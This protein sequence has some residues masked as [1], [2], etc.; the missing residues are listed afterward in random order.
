M[1]PPNAN[2]I[3]SNCVATHPHKPETGAALSFADWNA[4][5]ILRVLATIVQRLGFRERSEE[6]SELRCPYV[7]DTSRMYCDRT[8]P[9]AYPA[10]ILQATTCW[11]KPELVELAVHQIFQRI[12]AKTTSVG[13]K[14]NKKTL[15][16]R[17]EVPSNPRA[18]L[19]IFLNL[20]SRQ[21]QQGQSV[22]EDYARGVQIFKS[23]FLQYGHPELADSIPDFPQGSVTYKN[24]LITAIAPGSS[25]QSPSN[26]PP[27]N[28]VEIRMQDIEKA[29][30]LMSISTMSQ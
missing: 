5:V 29:L 11:S 30:L 16:I 26:A 4:E 28:R 25:Q 15:P 8:S 20:H 9:R 14:P 18:A 6:P 7:C 19:E 22:V 2:G 17:I 23:L 12:K 10:R 3:P 27:T 13:K 21:K 24:L 1:R